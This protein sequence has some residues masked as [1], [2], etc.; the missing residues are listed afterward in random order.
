MSRRLGYVL[1][2]VPRSRHGVGDPWFVMYAPASVEI[3]SV[4]LAVTTQ[5]PPLAPFYSS[6][7]WHI[8]S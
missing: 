2:G 7:I 8:P 5:S 3:V 6:R 1:L 4:D